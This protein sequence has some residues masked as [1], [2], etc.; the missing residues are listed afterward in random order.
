[1]PQRLERLQV[2]HPRADKAHDGTYLLPLRIGVAVRRAE[3][4]TRF[5]FTIPALVKPV[6]G[7]RKKI[8]T[9]GAGLHSTMTF[10]AVIPHHE[11][12]RVF[13]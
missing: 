3:Q 12:E 7:V 1:M 4:A 10:A 9:L 8:A 2:E 5:R 6:D 11:T 13:L